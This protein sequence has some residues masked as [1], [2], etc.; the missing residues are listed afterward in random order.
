[1]E[2]SKADSRVKYHHNYIVL[3]YITEASGHL[4]EVLTKLRIDTEHTSEGS[5]ESTRTI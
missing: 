4:H 2:G 5:A 1:M 3:Q